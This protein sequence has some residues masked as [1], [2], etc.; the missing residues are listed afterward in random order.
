MLDGK[1]VNDP[2]LT[3]PSGYLISYKVN[4]P[5]EKQKQTPVVIA[6]HG[7]SA[8]TFEWNEFRAWADAKDSF[9]TSQVLLGG[10]GRNY[11]D[12]KKATWQDWQKPILDEYNRLDSLGFK[13]ISF[14][15]SSVG[16]TLILNLL[17]ANKF[18]VNNMPKHIIII[19]PIVV[20]SNKFLPF[21][22]YIG[23]FVGY[24]E[25]GLDSAEVG[26]W[27]SYRPQES[28]QQ[29]QQ[30][31][32]TTQSNL[33][34]GI[35]LPVNIDLTIYKSMHDNTVN[36]ISAELMEKGIRNHDETKITVKMVASNL[37]VFT[38]LQ[39]RETITQ[40]DKDLQLKTFNE[41]MRIVMN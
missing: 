32:D 24:V 26:H 34:R 11:E 37:H 13:N 12:F 3:N 20:A 25:T 15:G 27:Y 8:T 16:G 31:L 22:K 2:S 14:L 21:V 17:H 1:K 40:A 33:T 10:H 9:Y 38:R 30:L 18:K 5:T 28:L 41:M 39:G 35:R 4:N 7:Y 19:D 36:P 29:L 6:I 23:P